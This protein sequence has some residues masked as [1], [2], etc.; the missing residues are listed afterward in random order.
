MGG[1]LKWDLVVE[2][3]RMWRLP[4]DLGSWKVS[5]APFFARTDFVSRGPVTISKQHHVGWR[6]AERRLKKVD[7]GQGAQR[8]YGLGCRLGAMGDTPISVCNHTSR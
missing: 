4:S 2:S 1:A 8:R 5:R 7:K 6:T 3:C